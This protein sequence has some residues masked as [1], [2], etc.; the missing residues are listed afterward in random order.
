MAT[1]TTNFGWDIPQSTDLVKDGATAI[2]AL[3][4]DIDSALVDLKGGTTG[5]VLA[6][7]SNSD[8]DFTWSND[9][10][11]TNPMTTTGDVIY[12]SSG[13][14]PARLGIGT[15]G[16]VLTVNGGGTAPEWTSISTG[17]MTQL[18]TGSLA[19]GAVTISSINQGYRDLK[20]VLQNVSTTSTGGVI[21]RINGSSS[22]QYYNTSMNGSSGSSFP[23]TFFYASDTNLPSISW[24]C[25]INFP[26]YALSMGK[27]GTYHYG[28]GSGY[29]GG[30]WVFSGTSAITSL[31]IDNNIG[32]LDNGTYYLY[33]VK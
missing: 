10:G 2:A 33:G 8:L 5:Q 18:A 16:Q 27:S 13:S 22:T 4:Q 31:T 19:S 23:Q 21:I 12:S 32:S 20:L 9:T 28:A 30:L 29:G 24:G 17:A 1:T 6:K 25:I 3:G 26:E 11:F 15:T 14:T 7:A